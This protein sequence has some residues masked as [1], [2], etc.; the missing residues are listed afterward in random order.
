MRNGRNETGGGRKVEEGN[1]TRAVLLFA[2]AALSYSSGSAKKLLELPSV[3]RRTRVT[4]ECSFLFLAAPPEPRCP[5]APRPL[6]DSA[7]FLLRE[8]SSEEETPGLSTAY[9]PY[10]TAPGGGEFALR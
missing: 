1:S 3:A 5:F 8:S 6:L 2:L 9:E 10:T 7:G 4:L